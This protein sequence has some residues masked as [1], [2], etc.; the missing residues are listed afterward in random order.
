M[1]NHEVARVLH[2]VSG[3]NRGG[4]ETL[5]MN[6]YRNI[7]RNKLQFDFV[8]YVND[9]CHYDDEILSYGGRIYHCSSPGHIGMIRFIQRLTSIIRNNGPYWAI[10]SH[11]DIHGGLISIA[12]RLAGVKRRISHAHTTG[13]HTENLLRR[14]IST[15]LKASMLINSTVLCACSLNAAQFMFGKK[16][17]KKNRV[18]Y[19]INGIDYKQF[20]NLDDDRKLLKKNMGF[21]EDKILLGHVGRFD[22]PKNQKFLISIAEYLIKKNKNICLALVGDG[23]TRKELENLVIK[24]ELSNNIKFLG[25]RTNIP[26]IMKSFDVFVFP[27]LFEGFGNVLIEAQATGTPCVISDAV[28]TNSDLGIGLITRLSL[29]QVESDWGDAIIRASHKN[30]PN[31]NLILDAINDGGYSIASTVNNLNDIYGLKRS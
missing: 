30:R 20:E 13:L 17:I 12:A 15:N 3:M 7:N 31:K 28:P 16:A 24:K 1:A 8:S 11:T 4:A 29:N 10:H 25:V 27:S 9:K 22:I 26:E 5:I 19:L 18:N 14:L 21:T 2:I 6:L 23:P